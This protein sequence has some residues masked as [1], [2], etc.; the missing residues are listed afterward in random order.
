MP[1]EVY[2]HTRD[3]LAALVSARAASQM[4]NAA[5]A[6]K[7]LSPDSV[8][9][10]SMS[11]LLKGPVFHGLQ[12]ILPREGLKQRLHALIGS[13]GT[14]E[15]AVE[16]AGRAAA[17][18]SSRADAAPPAPPP[19]VPAVPAGDTNRDEAVLST[20]E[21]LLS[22]VLPSAEDAAGQDAPLRR[23][24]YP[25]APPSRVAPADPAPAPLEDPA[26][27]L[28]DVPPQAL[29]PTPSPTPLE[30]WSEAL[31]P[32]APAPVMAARPHAGMSRERLETMALS[33][34]QLEHV[35]FVA[36]FE[37]GEAVFSRGTGYDVRSLKTLGLMGMRLLEKSGELR[38]Y[39]LAHDRGQLF[40]FPLGP[41]TLMVIGQPELSLG[42]VLSTLAA[43]KEDV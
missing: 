26:E 1:N 36:A 38:S 42:V 35:V 27:A 6:H 10:E 41:N 29:P 14:L 31:A 30:D 32:A 2:A 8:D 12:Q 22:E 9:A 13:L 43:L 37:E 17:K 24:V 11:K 16:P 5:L 34:A 15:P 18:E 3:G 21:A 40:I 20:G 19:A 23:N 28:L 39:Y 25:K 4:L 7:G 33:F